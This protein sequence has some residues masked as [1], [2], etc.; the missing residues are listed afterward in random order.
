MAEGGDRLCISAASLWCN[1]SFFKDLHAYLG[2]PL[3][4]PAADAVLR[5]SSTVSFVFIQIAPAGESQTMQRN[6]D[7][8]LVF[9]K[10]FLSLY[11][12]RWSKEVKDLTFVIA[13]VSSHRYEWRWFSTVKGRCPSL[14]CIFPA[15]LRLS[16]YLFNFNR[17]QNTSH[18]CSFRRFD[19][20]FVTVTR[21][22]TS[23]FF[24]F[25][26]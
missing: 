6:G 16:R 8:A 21:V 13:G 9:V 15:E 12:K 10:P 3:L 14:H 2:L 5:I 26:I 24:T 18:Y 23:M 19:C 11:I 7:Q 17:S 1:S 22:K 4:G 20:Y 25:S